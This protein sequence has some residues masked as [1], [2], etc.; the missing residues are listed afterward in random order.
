MGY[1]D[2][3]SLKPKLH[4]L[5]Q[6]DDLFRER[7]AHLLRESEFDSYFFEMPGVSSDTAYI[8]PFRFVL[9]K[10]PG[11]LGRDADQRSFQEHFVRYPIQRL[12]Q[13]QFNFIH[14]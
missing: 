1:A 13:N 8:S 5:F 10:A 9:V 4:D 7:F 3:R 14:S 11:L 12:F 2:S 6:E